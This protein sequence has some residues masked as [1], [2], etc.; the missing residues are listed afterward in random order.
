M[1][2]TSSRLLPTKSPPSP[3]LPVAPTRSSTGC[4][5]PLCRSCPASPGVCVDCVPSVGTKGRFGYAA[6]Y[7]TADGKC[8][9]CLEPRCNKCAANGRCAADGCEVGNRAAG[10]IGIRWH[11]PA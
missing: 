9:K 6:I 4:S 2:E 7:K 1:L 11:V 8:R 10:Q 5:D 3:P